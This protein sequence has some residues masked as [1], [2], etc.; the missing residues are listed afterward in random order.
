MKTKI[1]K[2][3][4]L[5]SLIVSCVIVVAS[6]FVLAFAGMNIGTSLAGGSQFEIAL[7]SEEKTKQYTSEI[8]SILKEN[9]C[10]LDSVFVESKYGAGKNDAEYTSSCLVVNLTEKNISDEKEAKIISEISAK[11]GI[12]AEYIS[13]IENITSSVKAKSILFVGLAVGI[14][15]VCLFVFAWI[16]YDIFAGL[17]FILAILHNVILYLSLLIVTRV[18]LN[19]I[20]LSVAIVLTLVMSAVLISIYEKYR[21]VSRLHIAEKETISESMLKA[22]KTQATPFA[23][24][25]IAVLVFAL[26]M[27]F[28]PVS[29]VGFSAL[30]IIIALV[31]SIY[32][33]VIIGPGSYAGLLE[34]KSYSEKAV[35]SRNDTV[36]KAIQKK[37]KKSTSKKSS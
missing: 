37:I 24:V 25:G 26:L 31:V 3:P 7:S 19:L 10:T 5:I 9:G 13:S 18:Q 27:F 4:L 22:V 32:T 12:D 1:K 17:S 11:L 14:I 28:I 35:L 21:E 33:I 30:A 23:I 6:I 34:A 16:R 15:A 36:N 20:S 8:K 2:F 29:S